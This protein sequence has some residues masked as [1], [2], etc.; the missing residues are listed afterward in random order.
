MQTYRSTQCEK[1]RWFIGAQ[2]Q[3]TSRKRSRERGIEEKGGMGWLGLSL[4]MESEAGQGGFCSGGRRGS[5]E[6]QPTLFWLVRIWAWRQSLWLP[7][8]WGRSSRHWWRSR[9]RGAFLL[10]WKDTLRPILFNF[11]SLKYMWGYFLQAIH[12][13]KKFNCKIN[14]LM[15]QA[16]FTWKSE[17][18]Q[19]WTFKK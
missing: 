5:K 18:R 6:G 14:Q 8:P 3:G 16:H 15:K 13:K 4:V 11:V 9:L 7:G 12:C 1:F 17:L 10:L 2:P 19:L